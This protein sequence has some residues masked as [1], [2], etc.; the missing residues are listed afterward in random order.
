M[1]RLIILCEV[2]MIFG[3]CLNLTTMSFSG[4]DHWYEIQ[5]LCGGTE[6][7]PINIATSSAVAADYES[8]YM[9]NGDAIPKK[10]KIA[11][12]G[13]TGVVFIFFG[14]YIYTSFFS[15]FILLKCLCSLSVN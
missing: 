9:E 11:N 12:N 10:L 1:F 15:F 7:S 5:A 4:P 3:L 2:K 8:I 6:Q 13:H 14:Y